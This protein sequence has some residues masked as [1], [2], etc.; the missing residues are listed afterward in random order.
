MSNFDEKSP[1]IG[2]NVKII[3]Q[4]SNFYVTFLL[5]FIENY[6]VKQNSHVKI[7][8]NILKKRCKKWGEKRKTKNLVKNENYPK[9][10]EKRKKR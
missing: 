5:F 3:K 2:K 10:W 7:G 8:K 6:P 4:S 9:W 1:K